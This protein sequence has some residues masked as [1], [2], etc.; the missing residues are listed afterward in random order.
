MNRILR[1]ISIAAVILILSAF[2]ASARGEDLRLEEIRWSIAEKGLD[3]E[4]VDYPTSFSL[5]VIR[6]KLRPE[7]RF[8]PPAERLLAA[9]DWR[10]NGGNFVSP[11]KDQEDC[12]SCWAFAAVASLESL[13]SISN[14]TS[15][16]FLNLSEQILVSCCSGNYGCDGG[17]MSVTASFMRDYGTYLESCFS[18]TATDNNCSNACSGWQSLAYK[19][20]SYSLLTHSIEA[21]KAAVSNYGPVQVTMNVYSDF[22]NYGSGVYEYA[23]GYFEGGHAILCVG[24]SDTPGQYGGGFFICK[25]SWGTDWGESGFFRIGYSQVSGSVSF[26]DDSYAYVYGGGP[27]PTPNPEPTPVPDPDIVTLAVNGPIVSGNIATAGEEDWYQFVVRTAGTHTIESWAGTLYDNYMYLYGP[28]NQ[29]TLITSDDDSGVGQAAKITWN[30]SPARYYVK[31][32]AYYSY[33]RGTYTIGLTGPSGGGG[34][35]PGDYNGDGTADIAIFRPSTGLWAVRNYTRT[36]FGDSGDVPV[37]ADYDGDCRA[38]IAVFRSSSRLWAIQSLT[39]FYWGAQDSV[40][41]PADYNGDGIC[42]IA[43]FKE[44]TGGWMIRGLTR[45]YFGRSGDIPVV[46]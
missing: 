39:R 25:N 41:H 5:G 4:A 3:W 9:V 13:I 10:N 6:E 36:H 33:D 38:N 22:L 24:Y 14:N 21:L 23:T 12:G 28:N 44:S 37:P 18:Y 2:G 46:R 20:T 7:V 42:D 8:T 45:V 32:D 17:Y 11:V 29:T 26:G 34:Y 35:T 43:I 16:N 27:A 40:P 1:G 19:I 31:M 15:G 30:L